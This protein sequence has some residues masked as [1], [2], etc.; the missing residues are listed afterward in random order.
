MKKK[1]IYLTILGFIVTFTLVSASQATNIK[2]KMFLKDVQKC[3]KFTSK[4]YNLLMDFFDSLNE[5]DIAII[6]DSISKSKYGLNVEIFNLEAIK[7]LKKLGKMG[8]YPPR[9]LKGWPHCKIPNNLIS[10]RGQINRLSD[11]SD[12]IEYYKIPEEDFNEAMNNYTNYI[13]GLLDQTQE[14]MNKVEAIGLSIS[15]PGFF[16][17]VNQI[18]ILSGQQLFLFNSENYYKYSISDFQ[19]TSI[20]TTWKF[21]TKKSPEL[22]F[23]KNVLKAQKLW[24]EFLIANEFTINSNHDSIEEKV[25]IELVKIEKRL[26]KLTI[27]SE[28]NQK[29]TVKAKDSKPESKT[30]AS[31][32]KNKFKLELPE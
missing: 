2:T 18:D 27:N 26:T 16:P 5:E 29:P 1:A 7:S 8:K 13:I 23:N 9:N 3:Q 32:E 30:Q 24:L 22:Y 14:L 17:K 6:S 11:Y 28:K 15:E 12:I 20:Y 31:S 4:Q 10:G 19:L 25:L 21:S